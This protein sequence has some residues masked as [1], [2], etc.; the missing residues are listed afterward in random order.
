MKKVAILQ[1]NYI[2]WKGYFDM[3]NKVD[4]FVIYDEVQYTKN[5]WR[6]RNKIKTKDGVQWLSI[7]VFQ[8]KLDQRISETE[9]SF[10][11]W[12]HKHW[13]TLKIAYGKAPGFKVYGPLFEKVYLGFDSSFLSDINVS[14]ILLINEILGIK[15]IISNSRDYTL[16]GNPTEK[17]IGI[18]KQAG[19]QTYL[20]GPAAADYLD[21]R[22][23]QESG[24]ELEWM[25][26]EGY[27]KYHQLHGDFIH[28]VSVVDLIFSTGEEASKYMLSFNKW[29]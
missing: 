2:P 3:I 25:S 12:N 23:F 6:N 24:I 10:S 22:L 5:D 29:Q 1:S 26:Y 21:I 16:M 7:P 28:N 27:P 11:K 20:S 4:E 8:K 13:N 17:L 18:C 9:V 15:T 14:L 19:A